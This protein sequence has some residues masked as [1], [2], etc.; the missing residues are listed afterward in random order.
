MPKNSSQIR[1]EMAMELDSEGFSGMQPRVSPEGSRRRVK[2]P[3]LDSW[4]DRRFVANRWVEL[5][6]LSIAVK[7]IDGGQRVACGSRR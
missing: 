7:S 1:V 4:R 5:M 2:L 6:V 3:I